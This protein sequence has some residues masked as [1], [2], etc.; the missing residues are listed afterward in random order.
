ML[1]YHHAHGPPCET[2]EEAQQAHHEALG[3]LPR[4]TGA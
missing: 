1:A 4:L 2:N 3:E